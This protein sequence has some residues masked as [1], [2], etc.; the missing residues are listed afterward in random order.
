[1]KNYETAFLIAPSLPEEEIENLIKK[2]ADVVSKKR[3]KLKDVN[4]WGKRKLAYPIQ[5]H[6]EAFYVFFNYEGNP[7]IPTELERRF[8]QTE[9][10]IRYL[11][12]KRIDPEEIR[13]RREKALS[14]EEKTSQ[15]EVPKKTEE[16]FH[17]ETVPEVK[18]RKK[19]LKKEEKEEEKVASEE[20]VA[21]I[22]EKKEV[23]K[24]E[25]KDVPEEIVA[26]AKE[27]KEVL[28]KE[29][30]KVPEETVAKEKRK[31]KE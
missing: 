19:V 31:E 15:K 4:N 11:T 16:K 2:M 10:I 23:L 1:M 8:K 29:K 13:K 7:D 22:K 9:T 27:K 28:K 24:K 12:V 5:K 17:E 30:K 14:V 18:E 21:E 6:E 3:G 26:E 25:E 20:T